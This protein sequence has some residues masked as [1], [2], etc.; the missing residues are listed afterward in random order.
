[1]FLCGAVAGACSTTVVVPLEVI[2]LRQMLVKEQYRGLLN[3]AK[4]VYK[5]GGILAF[6]EGLSASVLQV[7]Q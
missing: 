4:T 6:Y 2:R 5:N 3:G 1:M 7:Q